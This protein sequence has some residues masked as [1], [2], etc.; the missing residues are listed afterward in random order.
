LTFYLV[1][2]AVGSVILAPL[3][4]TYGRKP[5]SVI[6]LFI[7]VVLIIPCGLCHSVAELIVMRFIGAFAGSVMVASAPGMVADIVDDEHRALAF[8]I[9]SVGPL[10][11]PGI[12]VIRENRFT[13]S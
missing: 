11:G 12:Y 1:G 3:S 7:F 8:S 9:W 13:C 5:V 2:L 10:N 4:E 6:S